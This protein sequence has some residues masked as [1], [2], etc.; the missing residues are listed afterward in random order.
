[1]DD[2]KNE[3]NFGKIIQLLVIKPLNL[4]I[5]KLIELVIFNL[6]W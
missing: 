6:I 5:L 1:V 4:A 2:Q 3:N